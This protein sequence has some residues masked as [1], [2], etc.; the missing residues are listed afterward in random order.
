MGIPDSSLL[1]LIQK[2]R[3]WISWG[4]GDLSSFSGELKMADK[5]SKICCD[6]MMNLAE[7]CIRYHCQR[8]GRMV[9]ENCVQANDSFGVVLSGDTNST[10]EAGV[11][12]KSCKF[13]FDISIR[14][15]L[16]RKYCKKIHPSES[17]R[18]SPEPPSPSSSGERFSERFNGCSPHAAG[19]Y[20]D[21]SFTSNPSSVSVPHSPSR[22]VVIT[23]C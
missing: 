1:Y 17:P 11:V 21:A 16:G 14:N 22:Y 20:S 12:I 23:S 10:T 6:C 8:C 19:R 13:C 4:T 5:S 18:Q 3:S 15:K 2:I 9:C 7:S